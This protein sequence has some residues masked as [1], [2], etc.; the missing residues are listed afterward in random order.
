MKKFWEALETIKRACET[1]IHDSAEMKERER[2]QTR[3]DEQRLLVEG[4]MLDSYQAQLR[5]M[6]PPCEDDIW[7]NRRYDI[8][9]TLLPT[10]VAKKKKD[11]DPD[12]CVEET[13]AIAD[14]LNNRLRA[15]LDE[16]RGKNRRRFIGEV[17]ELPTKQETL[18]EVEP[19]NG[20]TVAMEEKVEEEVQDNE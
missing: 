15:D 16:K 1:F 14:A 17:E 5:N 13:L 20:E 6:Q 9:K 8:A 19:K 18:D 7:E 10:I 3:R 4:A 2:E 11:A 12:E